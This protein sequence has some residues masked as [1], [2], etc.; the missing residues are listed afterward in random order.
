VVGF[1]ALH[2]YP[3]L[4]AWL[5]RAGDWGYAIV[6]YGYLLAA[7]VLIVLAPRYLKR[8]V[9]LFLFLGGLALDQLVLTPTPGLTWF[10]PLLYLKLLVSHAVPEAPFRPEPGLLPPTHLDEETR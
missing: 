8:P 6:A 4:V 7:A 2:I 9:A 1:V 3:F 5:F 10:L